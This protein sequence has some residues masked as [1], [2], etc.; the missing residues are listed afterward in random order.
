MCGELH[1]LNLN[2]ASVLHSQDNF[3]LFMV[4][5]ILDTWLYLRYSILLSLNL[6]SWGTLVHNY[7][8]LNYL[9][10]CCQIWVI[11]GSV[12][13]VGRFCRFL[14]YGTVCVW[15]VFF[16]KCLLLF[17]SQHNIAWTCPSFNVFNCK[18]D[19]CNIHRAVN[20]FCFLLMSFGSFCLSINSPFHLCGQ[21]YC[22]RI[23]CSIHL[24]TF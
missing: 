4:H 2:V 14:H 18:F 15:S 7:I 22:H 3:H 16:L 10:S 21:K 5:Y 8:F 11:A 12:K 13:W 17:A 1:I 6:C 20:V 23:V 19:F 9:Y 24:V